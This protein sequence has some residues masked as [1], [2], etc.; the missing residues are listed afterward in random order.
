MKRHITDVLAAAG[1]VMA[2]LLLCAALEPAGLAPRVTHAQ[3]EAA[4]AGAVQQGDPA[5][6]AVATQ[7]AA[8]VRVR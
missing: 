7:E 1:F 8:H 3:A 2:F 6:D 5:K 4:A